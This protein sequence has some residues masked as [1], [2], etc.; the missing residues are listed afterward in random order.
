MSHRFRRITI[1][2]AV[3]GVAGIALVA[4]AS[5]ASDT[6]TNIGSDSTLIQGPLVDGPL[7]DADGLLGTLQLG[8][9]QQ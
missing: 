2:T 4:P 6:S 5:A 9:F 3:L 8:Q 7:V 1:T